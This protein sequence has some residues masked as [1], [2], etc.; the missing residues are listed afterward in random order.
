M[1]GDGQRLFDGID[2]LSSGVS[3]AAVTT[4]PVTADVACGVVYCA[5]KFDYAHDD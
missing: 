1:A 3:H 5:R 4:I 2:F